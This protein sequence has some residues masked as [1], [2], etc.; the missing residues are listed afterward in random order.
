MPARP[1]NDSSPAAPALSAFLRGVERRGLVFAHLQAGD[2][3][4]GMAALA[5]AMEIGRAHV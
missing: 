2:A 1:V 4:A 3:E 5:D